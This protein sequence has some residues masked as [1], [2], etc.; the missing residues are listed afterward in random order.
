MFAVIGTTFGTGD[1]S[2]TFGLPDLRGRIPVGK[3]THVDVD[4]L[5]ENDGAAL[6]DRRPKHKH[7]VNDSGHTHT[8]TY[9][10]IGGNTSLA[11]DVAPGGTSAGTLTP[12]TSVT[13]GITVGPQTNVSTDTPSYL[14]LQYI[15]RATN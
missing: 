10:D 6:A 15:V 2:T 3:G 13:T 8:M 1:G 12:L 9:A 5:G 4:T 7:S 11:G 14:V